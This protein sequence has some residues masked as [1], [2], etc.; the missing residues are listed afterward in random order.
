MRNLKILLGLVLF[1]PFVACSA[2]A[3]KKETKTGSTD[4]IEAYYFHF[5]TRCMTCKTVEARARENIETLDMGFVSEGDILLVERATNALLREFE[6]L[7]RR[8]GF[9]PVYRGT[10]S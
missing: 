4:K 3:D 6:A 10:K 5:T 8:S 2:Q 9:G 1:M 7:Y